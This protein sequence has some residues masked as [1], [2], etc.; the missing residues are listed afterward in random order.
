MISSHGRNTERQPNRPQRSHDLN[1]IIQAEI[2]LLYM[3]AKAGQIFDCLI[4]QTDNAR[5]RLGVPESSAIGDAQLFDTIAEP[6]AI[7]DA[8]FRPSIPV[9]DVRPRHNC[10]HQRGIRYGSRQRTLMPQRQCGRVRM[11]RHHAKGWLKAKHPTEARGN[12]DGSFAVRPQMEYSQ[13]QRRRDPRAATASARC[14]VCIPRIARYSREWTVRNRLPAELRRCC[15]PQENRAIP[16]HSRNR[17]TI[18]VA[19]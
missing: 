17:R 18:F 11:Y 16:T 2:N 15:L 1:W 9:S 5:I 7:I 14:K 4:N 6:I 3:R 19:R 12:A 13:A 10:H 8:Q